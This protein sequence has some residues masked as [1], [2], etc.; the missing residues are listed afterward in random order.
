[1]PVATVVVLGLI[2]GFAEPRRKIPISIA[3]FV[4]RILRDVLQGVSVRTSPVA[5]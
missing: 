1:M 5:N 3:L 2:L 4:F